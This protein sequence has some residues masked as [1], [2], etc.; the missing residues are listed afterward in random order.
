MEQSEKIE[1]F[2]EI[3]AFDIFCHKNIEPKNKNLKKIL[4]DNN[5]LGICGSFDFVGCLPEDIQME[6]RR[7]R[8]DR[9]IGEAIYEKENNLPHKKYHPYEIWT[10][11]SNWQTIST[12]DSI[13]E[14]IEYWPNHKENEA[15]MLYREDEDMPVHVLFSA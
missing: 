6:Y 2:K 9:I 11:S 1:M 4:N 7:W 14:A 13:Q 8:A 10:I 12:F 5:Y 3:E 15:Q